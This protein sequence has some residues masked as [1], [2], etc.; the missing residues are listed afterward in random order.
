MAKRIIYGG[1]F[2]NKGAEA[3]TLTTVEMLRKKY[4]NDEPVL[5]DLFPTKFGADKLKYDFEI[6]NMHV[7]T[8][9]RIQFPLLKLLFKESHKSNSEKE[10]TRLFDQAAGF[11][12]ISGYGISSHNQK[13]IWTLATMLPAFWCKRR[14]IPVTLLPQSLG[15]FNFKGWKKLLIQPI[16]ARYLKIPRTIFI[17][18]AI[19]RQYLAPFR[20]EEVINSYDLVL[21]NPTHI[22][23]QPE[24][25]SIA[26]I[27]NRQLTNF[28]PEQSVAKLFAELAQKSI[29]AGHTIHLFA[30]A[31]D[32]M[33]LCRLIYEAIPQKSKTIL[34]QTD[35]TVPQTEAL[36]AT[37]TGVI[38][39]R[40][41]GLVHAIKL[42]KPCFV[43]GWATKYQALI[44]AIGQQDYYVDLSKNPD[45]ESIPGCFK[46]W[47]EAG[48]QQGDQIKAK[49]EKIQAESQLMNY[50]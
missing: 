28:M 41:H 6:V 48:I 9:Y 37:M 40:Y 20:T 18:E 38:T 10:I 47:L 21:L 29:D 13:P 44:D 19:S 42:G 16:I 39:A 5:L 25:Q 43:I 30:H 24:G 34:Y 3:L 7:R 14:N 2:I 1:N 17:R 23:S 49:V 4:P 27:P 12:D 50:L 46:Q 31:T 45:Q 11:Y 8:L 26:L 32:D 35:F 15:P 33:K 36:L 22:E